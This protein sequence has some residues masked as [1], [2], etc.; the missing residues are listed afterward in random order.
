[1]TE[2]RRRFTW[3]IGLPVAALLF[4]GV[5][6]FAFSRI[7]L[8]VPESLAPWIALLFAVNILIGSA[9]A[10][11]LQG[12]RS[13]AFLIGFLVLTIIGG[14]IA[15]AVVGERPVHSLVAEE[16]ETPAEEETTPAEEET[17]PGEEETTPGEQETTPA[18]A[19]VAISAESIAFDTTTIQL[20]AGEPSVIAFENREA[21]PHNVAIY[22]GQEALFAG[23]IF[24][25][26]D[27]RD[28]EVP[29]LDAG[30]YE[31]R[32]DVHPQQMTGTVDVA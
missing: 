13:F 16:E 26:P 7:L 19:T 27:S 6:I 10:A 24:P 23:E 9:L 4:L 1:M 18:E 8:A 29:A 5:L 15:G 31:F 2:P 20:P 32:C 11:M 21:V 3:G 30:S 12:R 28:Y 14:G 17:T 22:D 25:G